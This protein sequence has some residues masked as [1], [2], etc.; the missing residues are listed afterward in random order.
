MIAAAKIRSNS[1][2]HLPKTWHFRLSRI[3][4]NLFKARRFNQTIITNTTKAASYRLLIIPSI[5][6]LK[7]LFELNPA[8]EWYAYLF[9]E[10]NSKWFSKK[11]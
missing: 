1:G 10:E 8:S 2:F 6:I 3:I 5:A 11:P 7:K 9:G 4:L